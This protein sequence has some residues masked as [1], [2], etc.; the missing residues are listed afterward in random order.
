MF[1]QLDESKRE[2][3][4]DWT[5]TLIGLALSPVFFV[6]VWLNKAEMGFTVSLILGLIAIAIK[7]QWKLRKHIWFWATIA[8][9]LAVQFPLIFIARWPDT[10]MP[11]IFYSMPLGIAD[12]LVIFGCNCVV[13]DAFP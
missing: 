6:F 2:Q 13:Q 10:R 8:V 3:R 1:E 12:F 11:M 9:V 5:G 4:T 7:L